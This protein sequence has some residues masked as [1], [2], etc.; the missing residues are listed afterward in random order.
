[1]SVVSPAQASVE[2]TTTGY[3]KAQTTSKVGARIAGRLA[4]VHVKEGDSVEVG[5][6]LAE[7]DDADVAAS[8]NAASAR[9]AAARARAAT[10]R[11]Q[12]VE[13]DVQLRREKALVERGASAA[14]I[15]EDLEAKVNSL[16]SQIAAGDADVRAAA[17]E[18]ET[19]RVNRSFT[20]ITA[21][22]KGR[23]VEKPAEVGELASPT[24]PN[25]VVALAD[26]STLVVETDVP[27]GRLGLIK[28]GSPTEV[29]LDAFPG[30]RFRG[31]TVEIASR[32]DRAK[33]TIGVKVKFVDDAAGVLP[34]MSARVSFL[35]KELDAQAMKEPPKTIVPGG[36]VFDRAGVK[37]VW[38]VDDGA[39]RLTPVELGPAFGEGFELVRGPAPGAKL[40]MN[41]DAKLAD[42]QK[43]KEEN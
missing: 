25:G 39:L 38:V 9:V 15:V 4:K 2:L 30:K 8:I 7:I 19:L 3:V 32:V 13:L 41:P 22:I 24:N 14:S 40:V 18:V 10:A 1:V 12:L 26:F 33:A 28:I 35:V 23:V 21:P 20:K 36:A 34:D 11:A 27:E 5:Q 37:H 17:A 29:V 43:V 16:R 6:L 31:Q 42:R